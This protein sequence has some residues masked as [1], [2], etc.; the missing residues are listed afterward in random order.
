MEDKIKKLAEL[1]KR[2]EQISKKLA[3]VKRSMILNERKA[4]AHMKICIG[5]SAME[6]IRESMIGKDIADLIYKNAQDAMK[7]DN[8]AWQ[9]LQELREG[10]KISKPQKREPENFDFGSQN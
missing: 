2:R 10:L 6:L 9:K 3:L 4:D 1:E 7:S 8:P 5:V